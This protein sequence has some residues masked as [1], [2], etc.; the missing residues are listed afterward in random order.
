MLMLAPLSLREYS[1]PQPYSIR[2]LRYLLDLQ[3]L[4]DEEA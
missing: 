3:L 4:E 2:R 1:G